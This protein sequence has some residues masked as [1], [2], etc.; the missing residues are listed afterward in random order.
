MIPASTIEPA[1][2]RPPKRAYS[3]RLHVRTVW[4]IGL[5]YLLDT[6]LLSGFV[7]AH[8]LPA[9]IPVVYCGCGLLACAVYD[10]MVRLRTFSREED[11]GLFQVLLSSTL[12][13]V[14]IAVAPQVAFYFL[15]VL[16]I[17]FG[18]GSLGVSARRSALAWGAVTCAVPVVMLRNHVD[19]WIP[20][21]NDLERT[22]VCLCFAATLG[23]CILLGQFGR[24]LRIRV[25]ERRQMLRESIATL[26]QRDVSLQQANAELRRLATHDALTGLANRAL[27]IDRFAEVVRERRSLAVC[28]LDLDRFKLI[29]D[30]L[31][32]AAGD[33][34]LQSVAKRLQACAREGDTVARAGG[35][36]FL[37]LIQGV[38]SSEE[39]EMMANRWLQALAEPYILDRAEVH[40]SPSIGIARYPHDGI[41]AEELLAKADEAMYQAKQC[42]RNT[43]RFFDS[44]AMAFSHERLTLESELRQALAKGQLQ[45]YYQSKIDIASGRVHSLEALIRWIHPK[46]GRLLPNEFIPIAEETGLIVPIGEWVIRE[47]CKQIASW[48]SRGLPCLRVAINISPTQFRKSDILTVIRDALGAHGLDPTS[49]E[50]EITEATLLNNPD[51][52][53]Q[54]L[55]QLSRMGVVVSIDDFGA[56]YSSLST[57][58]RFPIDK[59][60]I[61]RSFIKDLESSPDDAAIVRAIISLAHGLRLK[62]V[63]EGVESA[64]QLDMLKAMG[65][66]QYQGFYHSPAVSTAD[67]ELQFPFA[68]QDGLSAKDMEMMRTHSKLERR[69][70][71]K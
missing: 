9:I 21:S 7:A 1:A 33:A 47:A 27:F 23:R 6:A 56:S 71:L 52:C 10:A 54:A 70:Q 69:R 51:K 8:D 49:L 68:L 53:A 64:A 65:C 44:T 61:D 39:T 67:I 37:L 66:D 19:I 40:I 3:R 38:V 11:L 60:Q 43:F 57:L 62:V 45:L 18:F 30:S 34:L 17:V 29:N 35:D 59:L 63:A 16:F 50:I 36:E 2:L 13:L 5:S 42:G 22:L 28:V 25:D 31:G 14:F 26:Q 58:R 41:D 48:R 32:H 55:D 12:Q 4:A 24:A 15:A 46:R 20:H